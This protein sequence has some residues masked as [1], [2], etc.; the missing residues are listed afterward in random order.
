M[1]ANT[2]GPRGRSRKSRPVASKQHAD[3]PAAEPRA[4]A[5]GAKAARRRE[6]RVPAYRNLDERPPAPWH[7]LPLSELLIFAGAI[8]FVIAMLRLRHGVAAGGPL[9][10]AGILA[11][12]LGT[13]EV[14]WREHRSGFRSHTLLLAFVPVLALHTAVVLGYSALA[15][16]PRALNVGMFAVDIAVFLA[17]ARYLRARFQDA[18]ARR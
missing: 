8:A 18:R 4:D 13:A 17:L 9:L 12:G 10:L 2:S 1:A 6:R 15:S 5:P 3:T 16:P 14:S 11:V 7:P